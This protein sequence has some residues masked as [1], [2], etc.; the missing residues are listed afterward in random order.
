MVFLHEGFLESARR[1]ADRM[2]VVEPSGASISYAELDDLSDRLRDQLVAWGVFPGD[3]VGF[4]LHKS[5]DSVAALL[6]IL[7]AGA[8][9]V[10]VDPAA[11]AAR[12]AYIFTDC[13]VRALLVETQDSDS[14]SQELEALGS[15]PRLLELNEV[16]GGAGLSNALSA[17]QPYTTTVKPEADQLAYILYTSGSTGRPKGVML[18]HRNARRFVD[19]C[20][21]TFEPTE[22]DRF[23]SHAPF[24][25]DLSILDLYTPF[26]CGATLALI[27]EELGKDPQQLAKYIADQKLTIWYSTPSILSLL[28][29]YGGLEQYDHKA[30]RYVL[31]AGEVFPIGQ[32]NSLRENWPWP[33]YFN[34][35]G[36]TETNVCTYHELPMEIERR[37]ESPYPIGRLCEHYRG[38]VIDNEGQAV[39]EGEEGE[40]LI[41]GDGVMR[42]YW[43]LDQLTDASFKEVAG[44]CWYRTGDLVVEERSVYRY[45]GRRDRMVKKRGYRIEL[46]EIEACLHRHEDVREAAVVAI[47]HPDTGVSIYAHL[48]TRTGERISAIALKAFCAGD[49]PLYM[50]PDRFAFHGDL[51]KTSTD[52][53]DYQTLHSLSQ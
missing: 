7:K 41:A 6:G 39:S 24:H 31:F 35:Y 48:S 50:V 46:G 8:A 14:L 9:Y 10:P 44:E 42:G 22:E 20:S 12:N 15:Q 43:N 3:R 4:Q 36:P 34:L 5:I 30:L 23:S 38:V 47:S 28:S 45:V 32:L 1:C 40:L 37:R 53:T 13:E 11:P 25:F 51:P 19:W 21:R 27:T 49:L 17:R 2:A 29:D 52:K 18:S 16:G 33:R 26:S